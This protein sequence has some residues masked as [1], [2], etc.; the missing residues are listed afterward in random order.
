M[1]AIVASD[2]SRTGGPSF[3]RHAS[4]AEKAGATQARAGLP[5]VMPLVAQR[6]FWRSRGPRAN[7]KDFNCERC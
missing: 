5:R 6:A 3:T 4:A 1:G 2:P 7:S